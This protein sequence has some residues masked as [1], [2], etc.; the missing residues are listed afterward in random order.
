MRLHQVGDVDEIPH[1]AAVRRRRV[2]SEHVD[3]GALPGGGF[4]HDLQQMGGAGGVEVAQHHVVQGVRRCC[5]VQHDLA[6]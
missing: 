1:A 4:D 3:L 2:G 5:V 6:H